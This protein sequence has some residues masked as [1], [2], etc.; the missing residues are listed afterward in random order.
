MDNREGA[1]S[2]TPSDHDCEVVHAPGAG[3]FPAAHETREPALGD[4]HGAS[5]FVGASEEK[6]F[7]EAH[8]DLL[9]TLLETG[10]RAKGVLHALA[11]HCLL[12]FKRITL[13]VLNGTSETTAREAWVVCKIALVI[14]VPEPFF[15]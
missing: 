3:T 5:P 13:E 12:P 10:S 6:L 11:P 1:S 4:T 9:L 2:A 8:H 14:I 7:W 15:A